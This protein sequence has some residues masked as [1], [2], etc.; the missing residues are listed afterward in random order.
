MPDSNS[1]KKAKDK[2]SEGEQLK[3]FAGDDF[4][5]STSGKKPT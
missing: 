1:I 2:R 5:L 3:I 4:I